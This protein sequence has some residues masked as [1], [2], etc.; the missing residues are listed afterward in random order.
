MALKG[1]IK[2]KL[3]SGWAAQKTTPRMSTG[4]KSC[5]ASPGK[6]RIV[7]TVESYPFPTTATYCVPCAHTTM[8]TNLAEQLR[9]A[10]EAFAILKGML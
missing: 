5:G 6:V 2:L 3:P 8:K 10:D 7:H 4:C 9:L 1:R